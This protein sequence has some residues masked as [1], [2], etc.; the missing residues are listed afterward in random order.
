MIGMKSSPRA[1]LQHLIVMKSSSRAV[2]YY[3]SQPFLISHFFF[4]FR[5]TPEN[6]STSVRPRKFLFRIIVVRLVVAQWNIID[7]L[8]PVRSTSLVRCCIYFIPS[9]S[10]DRSIEV[11]AARAG[12]HGQHG[13]HGH[14]PWPLDCSAATETRCKST[15][16]SAIISVPGRADAPNLDPRKRSKRGSGNQR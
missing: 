13:Q 4:R 1:V 11:T 7:S 2:W 8:H 5:L 16:R 15:W 12:T 3:S 14:P 9:P 10:L 6:N